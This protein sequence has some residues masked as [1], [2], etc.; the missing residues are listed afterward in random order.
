MTGSQDVDIT[1]GPVGSNRTVSFFLPTGSYTVTAS[2]AGES[3]SAQVDLTDG[4]AAAVTLNF[5]ASVGLETILVVTAAIAVV[6]NVLVWTL[7]SRSPRLRLSNR[8]KG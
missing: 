7:R 4:V 3:Q 8:A 1:R 6:A 2:Q 5:G